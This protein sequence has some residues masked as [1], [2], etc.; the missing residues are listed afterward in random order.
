MAQTIKLKRSAVQGVIPTTSQ[1]ELGEV[2]INTYDGKVYIKKNVGGT[3]SIIEVGANA[4]FTPAGSDG[5]LQFNNGGALGATAQVYYDDVNNRL[6]VLTS[7]PSYDLDV[8]GTAGVSKL[9]LDTSGTPVGSTMGELVWNTDS[10]TADL[11]LNNGVVL[12]VGQENH[13]YVKAGEAISNGDVVYASGAVGNSGKVVVSKYIA[14]GTIEERRVVGI[15][16]QDIALGE[17]GYVTS[18][19]AVRGISTDGSALTTPEDWNLGDILYASP[20]VAGELTKTLPVAPNQAIAIA[21]VV[22][23]HASNGTLQVRAYDL[24]YHIEELHDVHTSSV[25]GNDILA[26]SAANSRWEN[27]DIPTLVDSRYVNVTGDTMTGALKFN[28]SS[29]SLF[30]GG[31]NSVR[32]QTNSG[33]VDVGPMNTG[34]S[35]FQTDR[36]AFYF[37]KNT[38]IDGEL[39]IYGSASRITS[40]AIYVPALYDSDN[41]A[42]YI[43][44]ASTSKLNVLQVDDINRDPT[45]TLSG[46]VTGSATMTNLGSINITTTVGNDSHTHSDYVQKS[47]DTMTGTLYTNTDIRSAG[48]IRATGWWSDA[49][50]TDYNGLATE[51]GVSSGASYV[52]S[53]NRNTEGYGELRLAGTA[54]KSQ[55]NFYAPIMYDS[56]DTGYYVNPNGN[57]ALDGLY[58]YGYA[59]FSGSYSNSTY[60]AQGN[61][62][63]FSNTYLSRMVGNEMLWADRWATVTTSGS[64]TTPNNVFRTGDNYAWFSSTTGTDNPVQWTIE[65]ISPSATTNVSARRVVIFAHSGF[66]CDLIVEVKNSAGTWETCYDGSYSFSGSRWHHFALTNISYPTDWPIRGIRV[67]IDNYGTSNR[68]IG[69][70]GLTN[71]RDYNTF[72]YI[73]QGGGQLYDNSELTFGNSNDLKI[74]HDGSNSWISEVGT[75]SLIV[76]ADNYYL[77]NAAGTETKISAVSDGS[78][79]LYDNNSVKL[80][81]TSS[82]INVTGNISIDSITALQHSGNFLY[83][84]SSNQFSSGVWFGGSSAT[85]GSGDIGVGSN[86][87]AST[88]RVFINGGTYDGTTVITID[89][90]T[91]DITASGELSSGNITTTGYLRGPSTFTI[92][93]AAHGDD[94]G[95]V[96]IAGNLQVDGTT[97]TINSTIVSIDDLN[98]LLAADATSASQANG[99]GILVNGPNNQAKLTYDSIQDRWNMNKGLELLSV[100]LVVGT[101]ATDVGRVETSS[102]VFSLTAY[103]TRQIAFGNDTNGEHVRIDADG[104]V[105]IN[106]TA[107]TR[108]LEVAAPGNDGIKIA[109][110]N[111]LIG[112]T[113][114]NDAQL[115]YWNGT[116]SYYGRS[117]LGGSVAAHYFR[118]GG[119]DK[120]IVDSTG[121]EVLGTLGVNSAFA[122]NGEAATLATTTQTQIASFSATTYGGGKFVITA[123]DGSNRHICE[124]LVTHNGTTAIATQYGSV[125]TATE[126]ATYDVDISGGN[127]RILATSSSTNSTVYKVAETLIRD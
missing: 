73:S 108:M 42:Y 92:D 65:D 17:F 57:T 34:W 78:V 61:Y 122:L 70:I 23:E 26:W 58:V 80:A 29:T 27:T 118:S 107:P 87:T 103:T 5:Q 19:G 66:T 96:V 113:S 59:S 79:S 37:N 89:G 24:G 47:G 112:G 36:P 124:L 38:A 3:E 68:Y 90:A 109:S 64:I 77:R 76:A 99:A 125:Y 104:R 46:D 44:A 45:V 33:W 22:A 9:Q 55:N 116:N 93:P 41:T 102:G 52:V 119:V 21:F 14:N 98:L 53:Y 97:T 95:T 74:Y 50:S 63:E 48:Q 75:G 30:E 72:P 8:A 123:T 31:S 117:S 101:G 88:S 13:F 126:L 67:T 111:A 49:A 86:G 62:V 18:L 40:T 6:G 10:E 28:D 85:F 94:T 2:A 100:P 7:T 84:N 11:V 105:G 83:L 32:I 43:N 60:F 16:T 91:G 120:F 81:T 1:L 51:I 127:V 82:G 115:L 106:I 54:V 114:G 25:A 35:H 56:G 71:T 4:A 20:N 110:G 121:A 12:Q 15:A 69:Q 39:S